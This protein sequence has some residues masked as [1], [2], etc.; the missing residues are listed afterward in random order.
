MRTVLA[1]GIFWA[2]SAGAAEYVPLKVGNTWVYREQYQPFP[3]YRYD[4]PKWESNK[5]KITFKVKSGPDPF[6]MISRTD[7]LYDRVEHAGAQPGGTPLKDSVFTEILDLRIDD[8]LPQVLHHNR[9]GYPVS[10]TS[11]IFFYLH[12]HPWPRTGELDTVPGT[13]GGARVVET[14]GWIAANKAPSGTLEERRA[15]YLDGVGLY[16]GLQGRDMSASCGFI[17]G[18]EWMLES[19][20]GKTFDVGRI[21]YDSPLAKVGKITCSI[22]P[23]A[24]FAGPRRLLDFG[25]SRF[26]LLGRKESAAAGAAVTQAI[27]AGRGGPRPE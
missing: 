2:A 15:W 21:P 4:S 20:N 8:S 17:D 14:H 12:D 5:S 26:N 25:G 1:I 23:L 7:S 13:T 3:Y 10:D 24:S 6:W 16:W 22:R 9:M 11:N 18:P 27:S 19:F